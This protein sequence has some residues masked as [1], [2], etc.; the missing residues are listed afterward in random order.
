MTSNLQAFGMITSG[1]FRWTSTSP[2][3]IIFSFIKWQIYVLC[4]L[5]IKQS[6]LKIPCRHVFTFDFWWH[7]WT[8]TSTKTI[9]TSHNQCW[10]YL[11]K[12]SKVPNYCLRY[13][14]NAQIVIHTYPPRTGS[15]A[16]LSRLLFVLG[17]ESNIFIWY[18]WAKCRRTR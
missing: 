2:K 3:V 10:K 5:S 1:D 18:T 8:L 13:R 4:V 15:S 11:Y 12:V 9:R 16:C 7:Q 14:V 17:K 6:Y